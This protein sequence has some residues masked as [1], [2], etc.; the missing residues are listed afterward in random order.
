MEP[1]K[2]PMEMEAPNPKKMALA[3]AAASQPAAPAAPAAPPT[4]HSAM[5]SAMLQKQNSNLTSS[6]QATRRQLEDAEQQLS[7]VKATLTQR[8]SA[9][10]VFD[11][12]WARLEEVLVLQLAPFEGVRPPACM[13]ARACER[14]RA[15]H[16]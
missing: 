14:A 15:W 2:R 13:R 8:D 3:S 5:S 11:R 1:G 16:A 12:E 4:A 7:T 9:L 10:G 6:L